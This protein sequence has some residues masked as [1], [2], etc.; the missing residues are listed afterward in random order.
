MVV[1][2]I[3]YIVLSFSH[4][5]YIIAKVNIANSSQVDEFFL[6]DE[7][8]DDYEYL[9]W[10]SADAAPVMIPYLKQL[11][12]DLDIFYSE[13]DILLYYSRSRGNGYGEPD[14]FDEDGFGYYYLQERRTRWLG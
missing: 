13:E 9:A 1:V 12:Y 2:T 6:T 11:G 4:P 7:K 8:Y 5:D 14:S 3:L 10:L